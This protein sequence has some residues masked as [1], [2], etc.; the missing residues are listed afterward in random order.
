VAIILL[1]AGLGY[2]VRAPVEAFA[3]VWVD[4]TGLVGLFLATVVLDSVPAPIPPDV[5]MGFT[6]LGGESWLR[7]SMVTGLGSVVGGNLAWLIGHYST[8]TEWMRKFLAGRGRQSAYLVHRNAR[9]AIT[10][11]A[12]TPLPFSVSCLAGGAVGM[13]WAQ[14]MP[15]TLLRIPRMAFYLY[16]MQLGWVSFGPA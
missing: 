10:L 12:L 7:A 14:L 13:P 16:V 11:G 6:F 5:F 9:L 8:R 2:W 15:L 1:F 4:Q 3:Q